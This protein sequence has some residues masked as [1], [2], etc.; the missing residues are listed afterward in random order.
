MRDFYEEVTA[1]K[2]MASGARHK[3]NGSRSKSCHLSSDGLTQKQI[4]SLHGEVKTYRL[5]KPMKWE[6]FTAMPQDLQA[7]YIEKLID[8]YGVTNAR[9][10]YMFGVT[11][12]MVSRYLIKLGVYRRHKPMNEAQIAAWE[13][14]EEGK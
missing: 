14:F 2:K 12:S 10:A 9:L 8:R 3:V 5:G 6:E 13:Q 4:A 7:A 1:K 11:G